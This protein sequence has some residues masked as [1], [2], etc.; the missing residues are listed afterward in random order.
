VEQ[1][2]PLGDFE[3]IRWE[4]PTDRGLALGR[5]VEICRLSGA[6]Q[7]VVVSVTLERR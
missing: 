3:A 6:Q 2:I 7:T 4:R 5:R 1:P